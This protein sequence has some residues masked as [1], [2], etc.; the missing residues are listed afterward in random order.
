MGVDD[1]KKRE[2]KVKDENDAWGDKFEKTFK[3][4][5]LIGCANVGRLWIKPV[6]KGSKKNKGGQKTKKT[7]KNIEEKEKNMIR[8]K[9]YCNG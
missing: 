4:E 3:D 1:Q 8:M 9:K 5:I 7:K 6:N 2:E